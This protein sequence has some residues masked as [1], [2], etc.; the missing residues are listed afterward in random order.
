MLAATPR[1]GSHLPL[2]GSD[3]R[4]YVCNPAWL[5]LAHVNFNAPSSI[6]TYSPL[7]NPWDASVKVQIPVLGVYVAVDIVCEVAGDNPCK[8]PTV[9]VKSPVPGVYAAAETG[10]YTKVDTPTLTVNLVKVVDATATLIRLCTGSVVRG[11][12]CSVAWLSL[13]QVNVNELVAIPT[14]S[15][16]CLRLCL[17]ETVN[18]SKPVDGV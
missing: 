9:I 17:P 11:Y 8:F 4:G 1:I 18:V 6:L 7:A 2:T 14:V 13:A 12:V 5:S 3:E 16:P 10:W 15:T